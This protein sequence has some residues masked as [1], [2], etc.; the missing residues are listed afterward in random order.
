MASNN[1]EEAGDFEEPSVEQT[2][3]AMLD[4]VSEAGQNL[5]EVDLGATMPN[6]GAG[7][8]RQASVQ[9]GQGRAGAGLRA[10]RR[11]RRSR[12]ALEHHLQHRPGRQGICPPAR[13]AGRRAGHRRQPRPALVHFSFLRC[14]ADQALRRRADRP[15]ALLPL[16]RAG[17]KSVR[18]RPVQEGRTSRSA[19]KTC[20]SSIHRMPSGGWRSSRSGTKGGIPARSASRASRS[21]PRGDSYDF[22]VVAQETLR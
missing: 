4:T 1:P 15:S 6:G 20:F 17:T 19:T 18:P 10:R 21:C 9:A 2:P 22:E 11:R 5:A 7:R 16:A 13:R 8:Q 12:T 14:D 3:G